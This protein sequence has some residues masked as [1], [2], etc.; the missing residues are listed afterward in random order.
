MVLCKYMYY[1]YELWVNIDDNAVKSYACFQ[2]ICLRVNA[3]DIIM[4]H[5]WNYSIQMELFYNH[6]I[7]LSRFC[8]TSESVTRCRN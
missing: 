6:F 4:V 5:P 7:L 1:A 2:Y 3:Y 8:M